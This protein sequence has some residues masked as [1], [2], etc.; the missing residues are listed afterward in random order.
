M[1]HATCISTNPPLLGSGKGNHFRSLFRSH[2]KACRV[3]PG[4]RC[5]EKACLCILTLLRTCCHSPTELDR[6]N[7]V[8]TEG[9]VSKATSVSWDQIKRTFLGP[10]NRNGGSQN[11]RAGRDSSR[12]KMWNSVNQNFR[13]EDLSEIKRCLFGVC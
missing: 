9:Q 11:S 2:V 12:S 13:D 8:I 4:R 5:K 1:W 6:G 7:S 10:L 3:F